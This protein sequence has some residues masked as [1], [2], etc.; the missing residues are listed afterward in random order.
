DGLTTPMKKIVQCF[1]RWIAPRS[2]ETEAESQKG[3]AYM[4][5]PRKVL[6]TVFRRAEPWL[7]VLACIPALTPISTIIRIFSSRLAFPMDLEWIEGGQLLHAHRVM[8]GQ[9]LFTEPKWGFMPFSY[10][11][12]HAYLLAFLGKIFGLDFWLGRLVSLGSFCG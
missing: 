12:G 1:D 3:R 7:I 11:P 4:E 9:E 5:K 6:A 2:T 8:N 10:P